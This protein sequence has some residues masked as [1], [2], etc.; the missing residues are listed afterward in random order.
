MILPPFGALNTTI[1]RLTEMLASIPVGLGLKHFSLI[2]M[3]PVLFYLNHMEAVSQLI[4][5]S[6]TIK[7]L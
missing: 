5:P 4:V 6:Y 3:S 2:M 7:V 1:S